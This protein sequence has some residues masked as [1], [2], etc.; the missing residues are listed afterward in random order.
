MKQKFLS[1]ICVG[2]LLTSLIGCTAAPQPTT[3]TP[4]SM[5]SVN[6]PTDA[7]TKTDVDSPPP[8]LTQPDELTRS[9]TQNGYTYQALT[10]AD[11]Q[12]LIVVTAEQQN[13]SIRFYQ[14]VD[15]LWVEEPSLACSGFVGKNGVSQSK[16]EGDRFTPAGLFGIGHGFHIPATPPPTGLDCLAITEESYWVD[17]PESDYYNQYVTTT[18]PTEW[19]S[20]EHMIDFKEYEYGFVIDYNSEGVKNAG[21]AIFFHIGNS[22]TAGCIATDQANVLN[23]LARLDKTRNPH[24]LI[25]PQHDR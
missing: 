11:C 12:Q 9:L 10:D 3:P 21:S 8:S 17:D 15:Q 25:V 13:A 16:R 18:D 23:Y 2:V 6:T 5:V 22:Y 1:I 4:S 24:I 19:N 7:E 14:L 20:A